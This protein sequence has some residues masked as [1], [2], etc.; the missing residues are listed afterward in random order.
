MYVL[1]HPDLSRTITAHRTR[2]M[3][4]P[5]TRGAVRR[6]HLVERERVRASLLVRPQARPGEQR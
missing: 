3:R 4:T 5:E 1:L 6:R 2:R